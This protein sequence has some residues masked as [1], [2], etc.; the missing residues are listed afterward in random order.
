[1]INVING[2]QEVVASDQDGEILELTDDDEEERMILMGYYDHEDYGDEAFK[3]EQ[4]KSAPGTRAQ[5]ANVGDVGIRQRRLDSDANVALNQNEMI[6]KA[7]K[8]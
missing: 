3:V 6:Q 1:M 2:S 7:L 8:A 5:T 4:T